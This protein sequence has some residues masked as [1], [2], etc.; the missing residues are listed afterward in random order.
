[1]NKGLLVLIG[2]LLGISYNVQSQDPSQFDQAQNNL[3]KKFEQ[4]NRLTDERFSSSGLLLNGVYFDDPYRDARGHPYLY[5]ED[6]LP[7]SVVFKGRF[8]PAILLRYDIVDQLVMIDHQNP[9]YQLITII[10]N[11]FISEFYLRESHFKRLSLG[12]DVP[13]LYQ[14]IYEGNIIKNYLEWHKSRSKSYHLK[15]RLS[16]AFGESK[17]RRLLVIEEEV[18]QYRSNRTFL[19]P[20]PDEIKTSLKTYLRS[21]KIRVNKTDDSTMVDVLRRAENNLYELRK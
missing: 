17:S 4:I 12:H 21:N 9:E 20:F 1:M 19:K 11:E 2:L 15:T 8:Y 3:A 16:Y 7:G 13:Q 6:F 5:G 10:P 18:Y 14:V